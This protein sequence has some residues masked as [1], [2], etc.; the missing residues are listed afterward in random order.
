MAANTYAKVDNEAT[1]LQ[2]HQIP[3]PIDRRPVN[4][5]IHQYF[6]IPPLKM[7]LF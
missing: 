1:G 5:G 3:M 4:N 6:V 2:K 7:K